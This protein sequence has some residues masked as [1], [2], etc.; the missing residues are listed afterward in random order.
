ML[1]YQRVSI[2]YRIFSSFVLTAN[3]HFGSYLQGWEKWNPNQQLCYVGS[4][5]FVLDRRC[6]HRR[7]VEQA[8]SDQ[9][10]SLLKLQK[11]KQQTYRQRIALI[12]GSLDS[13]VMF[14][15]PNIQSETNYL[16]PLGAQ[17]FDALLMMMPARVAT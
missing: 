16:Q 4:F 2:S 9:N 13:F 3:G 8:T 15:E 17:T 14:W 7:H 1:V 12:I 5:C 6:G 11:P 10:F